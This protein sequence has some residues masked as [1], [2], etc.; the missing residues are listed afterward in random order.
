MIQSQFVWFGGWRGLGI[1]SKINTGSGKRRKLTEW[2]GFGKYK[3]VRGRKRKRMECLRRLVAYSRIDVCMFSI[4]DNLILS[5]EVLLPM[6]DNF[7]LF[8]LPRPYISK[9]HF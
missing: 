1:E 2:N 6:N 4:N 3:D 9:C 7:P 8:M 5:Q